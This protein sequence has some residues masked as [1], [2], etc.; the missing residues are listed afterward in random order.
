MEYQIASPNDVELVTTPPIVIKETTSNEIIDRRETISNSSKLPSVP[1]E[2]VHPTETDVSISDAY[3]VFLLESEFS[4]LS[5]TPSVLYET[6]PPTET[7]TA[8]MKIPFDAQTQEGGILCV[9]PLKPRSKN[10]QKKPKAKNSPKKSK[11]K[12][13]T[14]TSVPQIDISLGRIA[15]V[16]SGASPV[17]SAIGPKFPTLSLLLDPPGRVPKPENL[18]MKLPVVPVPILPQE[19]PDMTATSVK[20]NLPGFA[21]IFP[22]LGKS[23]Y[24][25]METD[26]ASLTSSNGAFWSNAYLPLWPPSVQYSQPVTTVTES[27]YSEPLPQY[28]QSDALYTQSQIPATC[29]DVSDKIGTFQPSAVSTAGTYSTPSPTVEQIGVKA[30]ETMRL[31][32]TQ[33][34]NSHLFTNVLNPQSNSSVSYPEAHTPSSSDFPPVASAIQDAVDGAPQSNMF[35][36]EASHSPHSNLTYSIPAASNADLLANKTTESFLASLPPYPTSTVVSTAYDFLH[37]IPTAQMSSMSSTIAINTTASLEPKH[38]TDASGLLSPI[39]NIFTNVA[40]GVQ[41]PQLAGNYANLP[42][43]GKDTPWQNMPDG[44]FGTVA[45]TS[46]QTGRNR[47]NTSGDKVG[48]GKGKHSRKG[49]FQVSDILDRVSGSSAERSCSHSGKT[50]PNPEPP[51]DAYYVQESEELEA[52]KLQLKKEIIKN[53]L[54]LACL[55]NVIPPGDAARSGLEGIGLKHEAVSTIQVVFVLGHVGECS[56]LLHSQFDSHCYVTV[57]SLAMSHHCLSQV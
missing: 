42:G 13:K 36:R 22:R 18:P 30:T 32:V 8:P 11:S 50:D 40:Q 24:Q 29:A 2:K 56:D 27:Q 31:P 14:S 33:Y 57:H 4:Q 7:L 47:K 52:A 15:S 20:G 37:P 41:S 53:S 26:S 45:Y 43:Y 5:E 39:S 1:F 10:S 6:V 55:A 38:T 19:N 34:L 12:S 16:T 23:G 3:H 21:E 17:D 25:N 54:R 9:D 44:N 35:S 49:N 28:S 46:N 48:R 51:K